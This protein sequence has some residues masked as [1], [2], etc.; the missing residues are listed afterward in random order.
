MPCLVL[1][2]LAVTEHSELN[3]VWTE[4]LNSWGDEIYVKVSN[5]SI[6]LSGGRTS[7]RSLGCALVGIS[8]AVLERFRSSGIVS[9]LQK[10][11]GL[12]VGGWWPS[13][14]KTR[15]YPMVRW[16]AHQNVGGWCSCACRT[17]CCT[18]MRRRL[19]RL[20]SLRSAPAAGRRSPLAFAGRAKW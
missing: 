16:C 15:G 17:Y 11:E 9:G 19:Q 4:L 14:G 13:R 1:R 18:R 8:A 12:G 5:G 6:S 2:A 10:G 20:L 7:L 3:A